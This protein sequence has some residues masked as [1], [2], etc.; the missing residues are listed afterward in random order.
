MQALTEEQMHEALMRAVELAGG[1]TQ[2]A[3]KLNSALE[4]LTPARSHAAKPI[5]QQNVDWWLRR[6]KK[7]PAEL[8]RAAEMA[9]DGRVTRYEFR[10]DVFGVSH[11]AAPLVPLQFELP[12]A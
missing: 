5:R 7:L 1:Q 11:D 6:T 12:T 4:L 3:E 9:V 2:F 8:A 10:P